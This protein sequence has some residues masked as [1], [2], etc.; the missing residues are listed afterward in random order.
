MPTPKH[1]LLNALYLAPGVSGGPE[2]YLRG[3]A[4]ALAEQFPALELTV[5]TTISGA[6]AL[7]EDGWEE[8]MNVLELPCEDGQRVRRQWAEQV[9]LPRAARSTRAEIVH[10][11]A[12]VAP[13]YAGARA[14]VTLH[15]VTFLMR[16]TFGRLTTWGMTLLVKSAARRAD[17]LIAGTAA[18]RDEICSVLGIDASRFTVVHHGHDAT[19]SVHPTPSEELRRRYGLGDSRVVLCVAAKRPHKNQE[20]LIRAVPMLEPDTELLLAGHPESYELE[21]RALVRKLDL[22]G[23][24]RFAGYIPADDLEGLWKLASCAAFPTLGEGF[25]IPVIE[26]LAHGVPV[27]CSRL[28]VLE[29]IGGTLPHYF[30]PHD[31]ADAARSI[32]DALADVDTAGLGPVHASRYTWNAAAQLTH[33]TYEQA[34]ASPPR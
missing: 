1:V 33:E 3:L 5:A 6:A 34:L 30:D 9:L 4:P 8:H 29:E 27:A 13:V 25:G 16:P 26:A 15:D 28:P 7:R 20:L 10:S 21:L 19:Q 32:R 14:V 31:P 18:A 24:V 12:S 23:R 22:D 17:R 2:T 11:L